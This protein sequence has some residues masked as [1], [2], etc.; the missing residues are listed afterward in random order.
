MDALPKAIHDVQ[1]SDSATYQLLDFGLATQLNSTE[2]GSGFYV[3]NKESNITHP[4]TPFSYLK[5]DIAYKTYIAYVWN[6][7]SAQ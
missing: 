6:V 7:V 4:L 3:C 1:I 5:Q 2:L